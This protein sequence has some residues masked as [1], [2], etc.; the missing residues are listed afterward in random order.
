MQMNSLLSL[1]HSLVFQ[2]MCVFILQGACTVCVCGMSSGAH[3]C[4]RL[5]Y[6][7]LFYSPHARAD[8][9]ERTT[10]RYNRC[11]GL[12]LYIYIHTYTIIRCIKIS[13]PT[14]KCTRK[15]NKIKG[16]HHHQQALSSSFFSFFVNGL[17]MFRAGLCAAIISNN[18]KS[19]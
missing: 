8:G 12:Q 9:K 19:G 10:T 13:K 3:I 15:K 6:S 4:A 18:I 1:S 5:F 7:F 16:A 2:L 14:G 17:S 11:W